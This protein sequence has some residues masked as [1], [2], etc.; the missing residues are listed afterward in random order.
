MKKIFLL[1]T[2]LLAA[3]SVAAQS[4]LMSSPGIY[5]SPGKLYSVSSDVYG[6]TWG[7]CAGACTNECMEAKQGTREECDK[8]CFDKCHPQPDVI[9]RKILPTTS[10]PSIK[11][12]PRT[13]DNICAQ[14]FKVCEDSKR[15]ADC[16][17]LFEQCATSCAPSEPCEVKCKRSA[18]QGGD[19]FTGGI[20]D[21]GLYVECITKRC[22]VPCKKACVA[23]YGD[24][25]ENCI[26][27]LCEKPIPPQSC[28]GRCEIIRDD[29]K[30]SHIE[31]KECQIKIDNCKRNC[32]PDCPP[33]D[34]CVNRCTKS[35]YE[36][37]SD[38][39]TCKVLVESC[40]YAC[41]PGD[42]SSEP[43]TTPITPAMC[44]ERCDRLQD[45]C[46]LRCTLEDGHC[47]AVCRGVPNSEACNDNCETRRNAC[48][49]ECGNERWD[50]RGDCRRAS[51]TLDSSGQTAE[52]APVTESNNGPGE[53][54]AKKGLF[55]RLWSS[56]AG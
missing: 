56:F 28:E 39:E 40:L 47:K 3:I 8:M 12:E 15:G 38:R 31:P 11:P 6:T 27:K 24:A 16:K 36:C 45:A 26:I 43:E 35:Y 48:R 53:A 34:V 18:T 2:I 55:A 20:F 52:S 51:E 42:V 22:L 4:E 14:K 19:A 7:Q 54:Q 30:A 29:C 37:D 17:L 32:K 9:T 21:A 13:C 44:P 46:N 41:H 23:A 50:C 49:S 33:V 25:S 10:I 5:A 1:I